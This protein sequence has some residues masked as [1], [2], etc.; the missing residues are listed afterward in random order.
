MPAPRS[1][2]AVSSRGISPAIA[3]AL[4]LCGAIAPR[5][6]V[7][8]H[9]AWTAQVASRGQDGA[10]VGTTAATASGL[11]GELAGLFRFGDCDGPVCFPLADGS[12]GQHY[13]P[14]LD[15]GSSNGLGFLTGSI[16][17]TVANM[18]MSGAGSGALFRFENGRPVRE[19]ISG[20]PIFAER[21][22]TL[23]RGRLFV[24]ASMRGFDFATL[25]GVPLDGLVFNFVHQDMSPAGLGDPLAEHDVIQVTTRMNVSIL[26]STFA[27]SFGLLDRV[28]IGFALPM[29]RTSIEGHSTAR[30]LPFGPDSPHSFGT[31]DDPRY[32]AESR[33]F[34]SAYGLGDV[35]AR[36][37][38]RLIEAPHA[39]VSVVGEAR[40]PT[41]RVEDLLGAGHMTWRAIG[42]ASARY[43]D[44]SPHLNVGYLSR[45]NDAE[46]DAV[47]ATLGFDQIIAPFATLAVDVISSWQ[48]GDNMI[49]PPPPVEFPAPSGR[50]VHLTNIPSRRDDFLDASL[51]VRLTTSDGITFVTNAVIPVRRAGG[52]QP[53]VGWT[54]GLE[55][56]F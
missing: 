48:T 37:K 18:P 44:F 9:P 2:R 17:S 27:A 16:G 20:G 34:G 36:V 11:V 22:R 55:Y 45:Q 24:G 46:R 39:G 25:R 8:Q 5:P 41:G 13:S 35:A 32:T 7:A 42:V 10:S 29:V 49:P 33:V 12:H 19:K 53:T 43:G 54:A 56:T 40:F 23:G 31:A 1:S 14:P 6:A 28:D 15:A 51:G 47:L 3:G 21:A 50:V 4:L 38:A 52:L 26:I 30:V